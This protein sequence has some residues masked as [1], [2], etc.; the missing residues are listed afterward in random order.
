MKKISYINIT[1]LSFNRPLSL[2]K[3]K[4][5]S[6]YMH[7]VAL[8]STSSASGFVQIL[9]ICITSDNTIQMKEPWGEC[10]PYFCL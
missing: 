6:H 3:G 1:A 8:T 4:V 10:R 7:F 5:N 9:T 2:S